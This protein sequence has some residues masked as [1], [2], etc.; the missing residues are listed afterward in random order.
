MNKLIID[1]QQYNEVI[2]KLALIVHK[3]YKP[4]I[5]IGIMRGAG[6]IVDILSRLLKIP[7]AY[8]VIQ[9]YGGEGIE[10]IQGSLKFA[11]HIT[12]I[13]SKN[14]FKNILLVDDLSDTGNTFKNTIDWL[15]NN[16]MIKQYIHQIKTACLWKKKSS[17]FSPDFCPVHLTYDPWIVQ[18]NERYEETTIHDIAKKYKKN[19]NSIIESI[20]INYII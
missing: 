4:T 16:D 17:S 5:L 6:P 3:N 14:D 15:E 13:A 18:P 19:N 11:E 20:N 12:S 2:E 8:I 9:S 1:Y 10:D 7:V